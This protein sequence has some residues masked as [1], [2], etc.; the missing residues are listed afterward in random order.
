MQ[1]SMSNKMIDPKKS[2]KDLIPYEV[3]LFP[4]E[5]ELKLDANENIF[6]C[7]QKVC[8]ALQNLTKEQ[9]SRY[10]HYGKLTKK[11]SECTGVPIEWIKVT[12]GADEALY[13]LMQ[14]YLSDG[15]IMLTTTPS[16]S[17]PKIYAKIVGA[18][19]IEIPYKKRWVFPID[20]FLNEI[21]NNKKIKVINLTS[22]NN[23]T[24]ECI[25]EETAQRIL[26]AARDKIIIFDETYASYCSQSMIS[27]VKDYENIAIVKSLS[28]DF[29]LAGLRAGYII[30][31]PE[32]IKILKTI[33]S[34]YSVNI[35]AACA[36]E[37][38]LSDIEH[39]E[40]IKI[41]I[42]K[43]KEIL[44]K[45]FKHLHFE[46][47][48]SEANFIL[49][50]CFDKAQY[51]YH[52]LLKHGI[53]VRKFSD[54]NLK[55]LIRITVPDCN[56]AEK[57]IT[58]LQPKPT[59]IF[60]MD[61]VLVD[62][63]KSYR[64]AIKQ[65]YEYFANKELDYEEITQA[66]NLGGLNNDWDLTEY[67]LKRD[68]FS[69]DKNKIIEVFEKIYFA[70][71]DGL[72]KQEKFLLD[73][74]ILKTLAKKYNL[75]IFTGRPESEAVYTLNKN[76]VLQYFYPLV[77]MDNIP[78]DRQKPDKYGIELIKTKLM[79]TEIFYFGDTKDD[80]LCGKSA[81]VRPIGILAPQNQQESAKLLLKD[82]G[83]EVVLTS[84]N[85]ILTVTERETNAHSNKNE[86]NKRNS[87][88][89][90]Y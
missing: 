71:G 3:P 2:V 31:H 38:A 26:E 28:K 62:V 4:E 35:A 67:L 66:K 76:Q 8:E 56:N 68:G 83:A 52:T 36:A 17:M 75:A 57:I 88:L 72:I 14:A 90:K 74:D 82:S 25:T 1:S 10:P 13:S 29:A 49:V 22:P 11:I 58:I 21:K 9:I 86:R 39:L 80:I 73:K 40:K 5:I 55:G 69:I 60:D 32:R 37:A 45:G 43:S 89:C 77:T 81:N 53:K 87:N 51:I 7:S 70:N 48:P 34:P 12:N 20:E 41:E 64:A 44:T 6:G 50:N 16:F 19:V 30:S 24:G 59:L 78:P 85:E 42:E 18:S 33:I 47:Y 63:S 65:T 84:V 61:G 27:R 79:H 54:E 23:P 15:D 46:V